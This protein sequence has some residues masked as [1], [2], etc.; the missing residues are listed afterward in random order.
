M[1][2]ITLRQNIYLRSLLVGVGLVLFSL[3]I[4]ARIVYVQQV[5][6]PQWKERADNTRFRLIPAQRGNIFSSDGSLMV[7]SLPNYRVGIDLSTSVRSKSDS[8][9]FFRNLDSLCFHLNR[10]FPD[11]SPQRFRLRLTTARQNLLNI[12]AWNA[13]QTDTSQLR[14]EP[15]YLAL[16]G[17]TISYEQKKWFFEAT[18]WANLRRPTPAERRYDDSLARKDR[19]YFRWVRFDSTK[20]FRTGLNFE[21]FPQRVKPFGNTA[22]RLLGSVRDSVGRDS[23]LTSPGVVFMKGVTGIERGFNQVL[24]GQQ[25]HGWFENL[26]GSWRPIDEDEQHDAVPG[27]DLYTTIDINL[28][29]ITEAALL[30]AVK[31][32]RA[33]YGTAIVME[34][35]TGQIKAI[36]NLKRIKDSTYADVQNFAVDYRIA[37]GSTFKLA[38][39]MALFEKT[40]LSPHDK[41][42]TT[43]EFMQIHDSNNGIGYG[44]LSVK[45]IFERSSNTGIARLAVR[46]FSTRPALFVNAL[47]HYHLTDNLHFQA[48]VT[49]GNERPIVHRP[50]DRYWSTRSIPSMSIGA[51]MQMSALQLLAFY[52]AVANNG[53]WVQ[54]YVV[55]YAKRGEVVVQDYVQQHRDPEP[56]CSA[57]T[58]AIMKD[59]LEGVVS[60]KHGTAYKSV[61]TTQY[62]IAGK[63]GTAKKFIKGRQSNLYY[64]SFA[65]YFPA[66]NPKYTMLVGLDEPRHDDGSSVYG[67]T[68]A[69]PVFRE[70]A[71][72]IHALDV[73]I[74]Q[75]LAGRA[76]SPAQWNTQLGNSHPTDVLSIVH[77]LGIRTSASGWDDAPRGSTQKVPNLRGM[78]LRDALY[79]LENRG[80]SVSFSGKGKVY[81]QSLPVGVLPK[82]RRISLELR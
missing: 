16:H 7:T 8:A 22:S 29:D 10:L 64:S 59:M 55:A 15:R 24:K 39:M 66:D 76:G 44:T 42:Q 57:R 63:T 6:G 74:H 5:E 48:G 45:E 19:F 21:A 32:Y 1:A 26:R 18:R 53:Y 77:G 80:Y 28:Q 75:P 3:G 35:H 13:A 81:S 46:Y 12:M 17:K 51:E 33:Q 4:A 37:P 38:T 36:A 60:E 70:I 68:A 79:V 58:L 54:P 25:G 62:R 67:G 61:F 56:L 27:L 14:P 43:G 78:S 30:K 40:K 11:V 41:L 49:P 2:T 20:T 23:Q 9:H 50:G 73:R 34:T 52:N 71:D 31:R 72:K 82:E 47:D 69:A 65:G